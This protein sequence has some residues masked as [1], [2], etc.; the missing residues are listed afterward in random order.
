M[1]TGAQTTRHV[2]VVCE[3]DRA[4]SPVLAQLLRREAE[5]RGLGTA[6]RIEDA[7]LRARPGEPLLP[8]VERVV[9]PLGLG[10]ENHRSTPLELPLQ[11]P[12]ELVLTMTEEQRRTVVRAQRELLDRAFTVREALRLLSSRWW[13][14]RW[15]GTSYV[16]ARL[17]RVRP[18]VRPAPTPED[19]ADPA[20]GGRRLAGAVVDELSRASARL[21]ASLWGPAGTPGQTSTVGR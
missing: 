11:D 4:R 21:A 5:R 9:R 7:G 14:P 15:E 13:D 6:V 3:A 20:R 17:H 10:L 8:S 18:L 16:V 1:T 12:A 2:L 19:V